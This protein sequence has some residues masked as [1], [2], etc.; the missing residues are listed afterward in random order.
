MEANDTKVNK[1]LGG[2]NIQ[3][4]MNWSPTYIHHWLKIVHMVILLWQWGWL[5]WGINRGHKLPI[6]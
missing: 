6:G 1:L 2:Q 4:S 3:M 5:F